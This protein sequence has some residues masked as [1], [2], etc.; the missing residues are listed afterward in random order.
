MLEIVVKIVV[1]TIIVLNFICSINKLYKEYKKSETI[2]EQAI[3]WVVVIIF[4]TPLLI[5][6]FDLYNWP[7]KIG[8]V[9]A[10]N[11]IRWFEFITAYL[12]AIISA[13]IGAVVLIV[14]TNK[15]INLQREK[16]NEDM[17][18]QN[19]PLLTYEISE[20]RLEEYHTVYLVNG[21]SESNRN[22]NLYF[23]IQNL[24]LNHARNV[25]C[26]VYENGIK[27]FK[28]ML[29]LNQSIIKKDKSVCLNLIFNY[30]YESNSNKNYKEIDIEVFY[31]DLLNNCYSQKIKNYL[32]ITNEAG[33]K[34]GG[35]R[36]YIID[37]VIEK[38]KL[39]KEQ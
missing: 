18:I 39:L 16:D 23:T 33:S 27:I 6:Y 36:F 3:F 2:D 28:S 20:E 37:S 7:S 9:N 30:N 5:Y 38:E 26:A 21:N 1:F 22:Y 14:M 12:S 34:Y 31:E 29:K 24:G 8:W 11:S 19:L 15:Q 13:L 10:Q 17:R 35:Y 4:G 32:E 25:S